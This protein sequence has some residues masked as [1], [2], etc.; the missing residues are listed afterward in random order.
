MKQLHPIV[1]AIALSI[2]AC[3]AAQAANSAPDPAHVAAASEGFLQYHPDLRWRK[4]GLGHY[5][6]GRLDLALEALKRSARYADKGSQALVAEMYWKG[7]G[8]PVDRAAAY[9][10]MDLAAERG[11]KDFLAVREHY[12]SELSPEEPNR[13]QLI[14]TAFFIGMGAGTLFV[15]PISDD[16]RAKLKATTI[17]LEGSSAGS[18][19]VKVKARDLVTNFVADP[20]P[21]APTGAGSDRTQV[22][23]ANG[24]TK[25]KSN[26][27]IYLDLAGLDIRRVKIQA[28]GA[29]VLDTTTLTP[30]VVVPEP[31]TVAM[32]LLGL[33]GLSLRR[34]QHGTR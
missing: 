22:R 30:P 32:M 10:W 6:D 18:R 16:V 8:T 23:H 5:E 20:T 34:I 29:I 7:E 13:A 15:G 31:S 26:G 2:G 3:A 12:W 21:D 14:L 25:V 33:A 24:R 17:L 4:E 27:D 9:A 28:R 19:R 1:A 11:Y